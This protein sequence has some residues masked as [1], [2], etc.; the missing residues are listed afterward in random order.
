M[1]RVSRLVLRDEWSLQTH[2]FRPVVPGES[3]DSQHPL[4]RDFSLAPV[5][6]I[7]ADSQLKT[8]L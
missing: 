2:V 3:G 1:A 4:A 7:E 8:S 6:F 5:S